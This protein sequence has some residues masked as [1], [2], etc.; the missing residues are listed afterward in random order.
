MRKI[1]TCKTALLLF[2]LL[3]FGSLLAQHET[4]G[5]TLETTF[6]KLDSVILK[7]TEER[8]MLSKKVEHKAI[9]IQELKSKKELNYFQHQRLEALLKDSQTL[10]GQIEA[11]DAELK[12]SD[13][14]LKKTGTELLSYYD[15]EIKS[16]LKKLE[17]HKISKEMKE[18]LLLKVQTL[19]TRCEA[20]KQKIGYEEQPQIKISKIEIQSD[21]TPRQ[22]EQKA[23][24]LKDQEDKYRN[25]SEQL[26]KQGSEL[27][28]EIEIRN[29]MNDLV[30]DLA[31]FDQQDEALGN[32]ASESK[33]ANV[34]NGSLIN[35]SNDFRA[36]GSNQLAILV[37]Q[38][39]FDY[40][41]LSTEQLE[42]VI[43]LLKKQQA[44][45]ATKAD[46][47]AKQA[48]SFYRTAKEQKKP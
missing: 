44:E 20:I 43:V 8:E 15:S 10:A 5:K 21:D 29:R 45:A 19:R 13:K 3:P 7:L 41:H 33:T 40:G 46:S 37:G 1:N 16:G 2:L 23:D 4:S 48:Q 18:T 31:L 11:T 9:E 17:N 26:A 32:L 30:T 28:K 14:L 36:S 27:Q 12:E 47:L 38:K 35:P 6:A 34:E 22:I 42:E 25:L 39:D 24:L